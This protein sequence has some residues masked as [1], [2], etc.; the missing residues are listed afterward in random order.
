MLAYVSTI[1]FYRYFSCMRRGLK[2]LLMGLFILQLAFPAAVIAQE[3]WEMEYYDNLILADY[4]KTVEFRHEVVNL[5]LPIIDLGSGAKLRLDF[6]DLEGG[7]KN[8]TYRLVH[9]DKDWYPSLLDETEYINGFNGEEV[10]GFGYSTNTYS[11]YTHYDLT[12][13]ND[14]IEWTKSG[15]YAL[16]IVDDDLEKTV[17]V[18]RFIVTEEAVQTIAQLTRPRNTAK[19]RSHQEIKME[20][21]YTGLRI[22]RPIQELYVSVLQNGNWENAQNNIKGSFERSNAVHYDYMDLISFPAKKEF[23]NFDIRSLTSRSGNV[24]RIDR[25]DFE[26]NV[27]LNAHRARAEKYYITE[28]DANGQFIIDNRE[29]ANPEVSSEYA[30]VNFALFSSSKLED[31][32][33]IYGAFNDWQPKEEYQLIWDAKQSIYTGTFRFKQGYYD[34]MYGTLTDQGLDNAHFEGNWFETENDYHIIVYFRDTAGDYDRVVDVQVL[35]SN[36]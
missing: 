34:Y 26:T 31:K 20:I 6:D 12:I 3:H 30:N 10:P 25:N 28:F 29:Y 19:R 36:L 7:Y 22:N 4:I 1:D 8:Y 2:A 33:Y 11:E 15:N 16:I 35:N 23:R 18:R 24:D 27:E 32:V 14:D 13:P 21:N 5:T 9:C 17:L